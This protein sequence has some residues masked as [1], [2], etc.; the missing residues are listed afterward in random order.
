ML[1]I[2][3]ERGHTYAARGRLLQDDGS[4]GPSAAKRICTDEDQPPLIKRVAAVITD[5]QEASGNR[6]AQQFSLEKV[7]L[8]D[9]VN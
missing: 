1:Q 5:R 7:A 3:G 8:E 4:I 2:G 9:R 6:W